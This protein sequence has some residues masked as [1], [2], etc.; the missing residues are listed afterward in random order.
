MAAPV[1][2]STTPVNGADSVPVSQLISVNFDVA[3]DRNS[4]TP[5]TVMVFRADDEE[6]IYGTFTFSTDSTTVNFR[7]S[8]VLAEDTS[9]QI[10]VVGIDS[11]TGSSVKSS[12]GDFLAVT[13]TN[14]FRTGREL[15]LPITDS[16]VA[17]RDDQELLGPIR[18]ESS[19]AVQPT[20]GPLEIESRT[21]K[22]LTSQ[23]LVS[24]TGFHITFNQD[25]D[26]TTVTTDTLLV[27]QVPVWGMTQYYASLPAGADCPQLNLQQTGSLTTP[28]GTLAVEGKSIYYVLPSN[29]DFLH[30][31]EVVVT[32]TEDIEATDG[33]TLLEEEEYFFTTEYFPLFFGVRRL[34]LNLGPV[35]ASVADDTL[36]RIIHK[37]SIEAWELS[38]RAFNLCEPTYRYTQWVECKSVLDVISTLMLSREMSA[39]QTKTLGDFTVRYAPA[40]PELGGK[41][42]M[43]SK[44][45]DDIILNTSA[46]MVAVSAVKGATAPGERFDFRLRTWDHLLHQS[47]PGANLRNERGEKARLSTEYSF[48]GKDSV[49]LNQ[50]YIRSVPSTLI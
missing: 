31:T 4:I 47:A 37:N 16:R 33:S 46:S 40:D 10:K 25:I 14:S 3:V 36:L 41:W 18:E 27:E 2:Q 42:K 24:S 45:V 8:N 26:A 20:G 22:A 23:V 39:G 9:Y 34:R 38:G 11:G 6:P 48:D 17:T 13:T 44:C 49:F 1:L 32:V 12:T 35:A 5:A 15:F 43:A 21:P 29:E 7:P 28:D 50:F 30:N 19:L